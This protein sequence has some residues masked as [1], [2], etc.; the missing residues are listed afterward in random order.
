MTNAKDALPPQQPP[1][2]FR[3]NHYPPAHPA[4][5]Y[6]YPPQYY[7]APHAAPYHHDLCYPSSPYLHHK[8]PHTTYRR[9]LPN[10]QFYQHT[11]ADLYSP[12]PL[13]NQQS[14]QVREL[15]VLKYTIKV[16]SPVLSIIFFFQIITTNPTAVGGNAFQAPPNAP[17]PPTLLETYATPPPGPLVE[18]Y[19]PPPPHYYPGYGPAP[20]PSCYSHSQASRAVP[21]ISMTY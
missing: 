3:I 9:Y 19:P 12:A 7:P 2:H 20:P 10:A 16:F 1:S 5:S 4:Y 18:A 15:K 14:Q 11:S 6:S 13:S 21:F 8:Y 17:P